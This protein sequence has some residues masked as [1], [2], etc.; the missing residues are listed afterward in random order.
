VTAVAGSAS[1]GSDARSKASVK[2]E[3]NSNAK[4]ARRGA[5]SDRNVTCD[6]IQLVQNLIERCLQLYMSKAEVTHTLQY[7]AKIEPSFTNLVW[8]KLEEQNQEFFKAYYTRL[9][10]KDQIIL[11]N[12]LLEQHVQLIQRMGGGGG[13]ANNNNNSTANNGAAN[14]NGGFNGKQQM[15]G[16]PSMPP[17]HLGAQGQMMPGMQGP[18]QVGPYGQMQGM[19]GGVMHPAYNG[20]PGHLSN[21]AS[22]VVGG[23]PQMGQGGMQQGKWDPSQSQ[24]HGGH[25]PYSNG[26]AAGRNGSQNGG[27]N[28]NS[29]GAGNNTANG[30]WGN[31]NGPPTSG[32][33]NASF[34]QQG[35]PFAF[36]RVSSFGQL[37]RNFSLSEFSAELD[38]HMKVPENDSLLLQSLV[39]A[40]S[41]DNLLDLD[42]NNNIGDALEKE[43]EFDCLLNL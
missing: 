7:Q 23:Y 20:N 24:Q 27:N 28:G 36:P 18:M 26:G 2:A 17:G 6:D 35:E 33:F 43:K 39:P 42:V 1:M 5:G 9:Q 19:N 32:P 16:M 22:G 29:N 11:F 30:E 38:E 15:S 8:L 4:G 3:D 14:A 10:V 40:H 21:G 37:P 12:H 25:P 41:T 34:E 31:G 13:G